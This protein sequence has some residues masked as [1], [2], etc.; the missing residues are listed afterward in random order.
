MDKWTIHYNGITVNADADLSVD[1]IKTAM[2]RVY[3]AVAN[4][5]ADVDPENKV[6]KFVLQ[7]G[8]KGC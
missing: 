3:P 8:T 1:Q 6:I 4:A 2:A 7:A 5:V